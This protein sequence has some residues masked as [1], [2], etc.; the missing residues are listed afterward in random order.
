MFYYVYGLKEV[1]GEPMNPFNAFDDNICSQG[2][3]LSVKV[4]YLYLHLRFH[5]SAHYE[6]YY[7]IT[8]EA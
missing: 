1:I 3:N 2:P 7:S 4:N 5:Y 6:N 8:I